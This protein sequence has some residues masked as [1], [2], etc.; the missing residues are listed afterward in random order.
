MPSA[1]RPRAK[2]RPMPPT[3]VR[4]CYPCHPQAARLRKRVSQ[5]DEEQR[6]QLREWLNTQ[7]PKQ[8]LRKSN[9]LVSSSR[10][11]PALCLAPPLPRWVG[12]PRPGPGLREGGYHQPPGG[13][14]L[15]AWRSGLLNPG[16]LT[17]CPGG[18]R[19]PVRPT[20]PHPP[21][22][23]PSPPHL[24]RAP[25]PSVRTLGLHTG[26]I[27]VGSE[28]WTQRRCALLLTHVATSSCAC[29]QLGVPLG[30]HGWAA[31][32]MVGGYVPFIFKTVAMAS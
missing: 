16:P 20:S 9:L 29:L 22:S 2:H 30:P 15:R 21:P 12:P 11:G 32:M 5:L 3:D 18:G 27:A 31:R 10:F 17:M 13:V 28:V 25:G 4:T 14:F 19:R 6:R 26:W 23:P 1:D 8:I 7:A 24:W